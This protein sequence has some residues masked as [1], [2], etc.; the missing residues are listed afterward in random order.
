M[1]LSTENYNKRNVWF[2]NPSI[3]R[4]QISDSLTHTREMLRKESLPVGDI[5]V[6]VNGIDKQKVC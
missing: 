1:F 6:I 5:D 3:I 4:T 2:Q